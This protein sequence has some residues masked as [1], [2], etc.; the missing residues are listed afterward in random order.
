MSPQLECKFIKPSS[1]QICWLTFVSRNLVNANH[2]IFISS[3]FANTTD[4]QNQAITQSIGRAKRF[5]QR[6][7]VHVYTF[8]ALHTIDIE[9]L[10]NWKEK[11]L[12]QTEGEKWELKTKA[13][14]SRKERKQDW[15]PIFTKKKKDPIKGKGDSEEEPPAPNTMMNNPEEEQGNELDITMDDAR[16]LVESDVEM[17][18]EL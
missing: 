2:V 15:G 12:V 8:L 10:Q 3:M 11:R 6:K 16:E 9:I 1:A 14:M 4:E 17:E 5:G 7:T 18:E 13:E